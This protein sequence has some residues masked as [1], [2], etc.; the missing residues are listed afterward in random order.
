ML[1]FNNNNALLLKNPQEII[2]L[3]EQNQDTNLI[4]R[5]I[6]NKF[7]NLARQ[8]LAKFPQNVTTVS[9]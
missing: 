3:K 8:H 1:K 6:G 7:L 2:L 9:E 4:D 5:E